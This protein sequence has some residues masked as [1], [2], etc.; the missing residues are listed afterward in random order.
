MSA[1]FAHCLKVISDNPENPL[2]DNDGSLKPEMVDADNISTLVKKNLEDIVRFTDAL[3]GLKNHNASTCLTINNLTDLVD[4]I[5]NDVNYTKPEHDSLHITTSHR[6]QLNN[7][8][9]RFSILNLDIP[10][11]FPKHASTDARALIDYLEHLL[12][13]A[14]PEYIPVADSAKAE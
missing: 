14:Y 13:N 8:C 10:E 4:K 9:S 12:K 3:Q 11:S 2:L 7:L 6:N 5:I 1:E